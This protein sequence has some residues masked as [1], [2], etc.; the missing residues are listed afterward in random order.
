MARSAEG[1]HT[2]RQLLLALQHVLLILPT[3]PHRLVGVTAPDLVIEIA[4]IVVS[5]TFPSHVAPLELLY[6]KQGVAASIHS[7]Y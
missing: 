3:H 6:L 7:G 4:R 2:P 1:T 5:R